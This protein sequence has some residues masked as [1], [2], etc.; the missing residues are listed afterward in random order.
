MITANIDRRA[1]L[2]TDGKSIYRPNTPEVL[3]NSIPKFNS[4]KLLTSP[5]FI[6][7]LLNG[8]QVNKE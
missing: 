4:N 8:R 3:I 2:D 7:R 6:H 1:L 5:P